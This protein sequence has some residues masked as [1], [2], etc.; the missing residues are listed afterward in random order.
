MTLDDLE[1][2]NRGFA[3]F[4]AIFLHKTHFKSE[5]IRDRPV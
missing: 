2:Q 5:I 1:H 4:L 3:D